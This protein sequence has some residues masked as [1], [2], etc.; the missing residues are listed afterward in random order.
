MKRFK[1]KKTTERGDIE[2]YLER[3]L[4]YDFDPRSAK[5]I[6]YRFFN[7]LGPSINKESS[8]LNKKLYEKI[9]RNP[10]AYFNFGFNMKDFNYFIFKQL[11]MRLE[12]GIIKHKVD[13]L[14]MRNKLKLKEEKKMNS[15]NN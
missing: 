7:N 3:S 8:K 14:K 2:S 15:N 11:F 5:D 1:L 12:R 9:K 6:K 4:F 10:K 13:E